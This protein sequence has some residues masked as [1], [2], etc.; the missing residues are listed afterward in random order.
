MQ[1][2]HGMVRVLGPLEK[3]GQHARASSFSQSLSYE[4]NSWL[5]RL[6]H[7]EDI[8]WI[9]PCGVESCRLL[10]WKTAVHPPSQR[11]DHQ[12]VRRACFAIEC[13]NLKV[14]A[15]SIPCHL[16]KLS[17]PQRVGSFPSPRRHPQVLFPSYEGVSCLFEHA[18]LPGSFELLCLNLRAPWHST[19]GRDA[20]KIVDGT[21]RKR[22]I[23][24]L[25]K[26]FCNLF[27]PNDL[28]EATT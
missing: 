27:I 8:Q 10:W 4:A 15:S 7:G 3:Q 23:S 20:F 13:T 28:I 18:T 2:S 11:P 9:L 25:R 26:P 14:W 19:S 16:R 17:K 6:Q 5:R 1:S 12:T 24:R 22:F 21:K